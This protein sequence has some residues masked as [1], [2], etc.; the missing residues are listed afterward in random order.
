MPNPYTI[1]LKINCPLEPVRQTVTFYCI[2]EE[3]SGERAAIWN[4]CESW[5]KAPQ[6][7]V[8]QE[9]CV[10]EFRRQH[11]EYRYVG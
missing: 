9:H 11:P 8:C 5:R 7:D 3:K 6:C 10:T 2:L 1:S 4:A